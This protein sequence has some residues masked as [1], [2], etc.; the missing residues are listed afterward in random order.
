MRHDDGDASDE[1]TKGASIIAWV[2][3]IHF[4]YLFNT[5][6]QRLSIY[7]PVEPWFRKE[8]I[9]SRFL[10][11]VPVQDTGHC[12]ETS[13][14][15]ETFDMWKRSN[16]AKH[17][18]LDCRVSRISPGSSLMTLAIFQQKLFGFISSNIHL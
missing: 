5:L 18:V 8:T 2:C 12:A 3:V 14:P 4:A 6:D 11:L 17:T 15:P 7:E 13:K 10:S 9:L 16:P 1:T